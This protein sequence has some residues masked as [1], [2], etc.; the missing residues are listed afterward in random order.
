MSSG[1]P[2]C[3]LAGQD[4]GSRPQHLHWHSNKCDPFTPGTLQPVCHSAI[5]HSQL[6]AVGSALKHTNS[7]EINH[8]WPR[9]GPGVFRSGFVEKQ[10][11]AAFMEVDSRQQTWSQSKLLSSLVCRGHSQKTSDLLNLLEIST[12]I[13]CE[14]PLQVCKVCAGLGLPSLPAG[15]VPSAVQTGSSSTC[16]QSTSPAD[17]LSPPFPS[18]GLFLTSPQPWGTD[19][20]CPQFSVYFKFYSFRK[21]PV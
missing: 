18:R 17:R 6:E 1:G 15:L 12:F 19:P 3:P 11:R 7:Q 4:R 5:C 9:A 21:I 20:A 2:L 14:E 10:C 16:A 8:H 13:P